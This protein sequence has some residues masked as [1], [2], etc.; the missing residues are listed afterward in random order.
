[1]LFVRA[2]RQ[3]T[4]ALPCTAGVSIRHV[5]VISAPGSLLVRFATTP[6][7]TSPTSKAEASV[8]PL[9]EA[10]LADA[11]KA[12]GGASVTGDGTGTAPTG[13]RTT[14]AIATFSTG[15]FGVSP[16]K[17]LLLARLIK[18]MSLE[19]AE[20]QMTFSKKRAADRVRAMLHRA[21]AA[22][23][24]NYAQDPKDFVI[25][26]SWTGKGNRQAR[27]LIHGRARFGKMHRPSAH[28]KIRLMKRNPDPTQEEKEFATLARLF[29]R[30]NLFVPLRDDQPVRLTEPVWSRKPW[31]YVTSTRWTDP[32]NALARYAR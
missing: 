12:E 11:T 19:E 14:K 31:K 6:A 8:N 13:A 21:A 3:T 27:M 2:L 1:M 28:L 20:K 22:V 17:L 29:K 18:G 16:K 7:G 26:E 5:P 23:S 32:K 15:T 30:H 24:H 25:K 10:A 9:F 4:S